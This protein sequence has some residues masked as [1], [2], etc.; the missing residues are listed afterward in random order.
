MSKG[1]IVVASTVVS[2]TLSPELEMEMNNRQIASE[3]RKVASGEPS[4]MI[5]TQDLERVAGLLERCDAMGHASRVRGEAN[6]QRIL[7]Y[8]KK[9]PFCTQTECA[10][11]LGLSRVTVHQHAR[12]IRASWAKREKH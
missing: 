9:R 3:L 6:R 12:V 4:A 1:G 7:R 5:P 10:D 8:V 2:D 11:A